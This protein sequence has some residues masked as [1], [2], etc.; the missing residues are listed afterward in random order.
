M[1]RFHYGKR[2]E[3]TTYETLADAVQSLAPVAQDGE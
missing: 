3:V 2:V 1:S